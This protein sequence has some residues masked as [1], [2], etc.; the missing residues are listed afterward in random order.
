VSLNTWTPTALAS[1]A[2]CISLRP[3]RMV[4]A[5]HVAA[6]AKLLPD[7]V[8]QS[9]L[10]QLLEDSK[11]PLPAPVERLH[12]LLSTPWR[13]QPG[14]G[15]SRFR[16]QHD[17]GVWYGAESIEVAAAEL[18]FRRVK[19]ARD[20]GLS[21][22]DSVPHTAFRAHVDTRA[23]DLTRPPLSTD[24]V[25]WTDASSYVATQAL[26]ARAR[27][28]EV[29]AIVYQSVRDPRP[30]PGWCLAVLDQA[31]FSKPTPDRE[32]QTWFLSVAGT[33]GGPFAAT[34]TRAVSREAIRF[35]FDPDR[36][37]S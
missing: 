24:S 5:Q 7:P 20:A 29:G 21:T 8:K 2:R 10:E 17:P 22:I 37:A 28:A 30:S 36:H 34:W 15:G 14:P 27:K 1:N 25:L 23:T 11:P 4:E 16:A 18:A 6:T 13:Y 32:M 33:Q 3:W 26:A 12:Y 19:F 31:A 9:L 35:G